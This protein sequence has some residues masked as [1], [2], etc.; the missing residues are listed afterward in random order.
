[1]A[2]VVLAAIMHDHCLQ[3][4]LCTDVC[5]PKQGKMYTVSD[6]AHTP[7]SLIECKALQRYK[8][9]AWKILELDVNA[10]LHVPCRITIG[11]TSVVLAQFPLQ[12]IV[13]EPA[14]IVRRKWQT[15]VCEGFQF[16]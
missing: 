1:M 5:I 12:V 15:Q 8:Q 3:V 2:L 13:K 4:I 6:F 11:T 9:H 14:E 10:L 16:T 7:C